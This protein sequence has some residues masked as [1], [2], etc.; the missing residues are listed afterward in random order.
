MAILPS[1]EIPCNQWLWFI[2]SRLF[3]YQTWPLTIPQWFEKAPDLP[4]RL[5]R[6]STPICAT[7]P[8]QAELADLR[9]AKE[10]TTHRQPST[11]SR[12][13]RLATA[14]QHRK[15]DASEDTPALASWSTAGHTLSPRSWTIGQAQ[16]PYSAL[17]TWFR[18]QERGRSSR[19]LVIL[20]HIHLLGDRIW[21]NLQPVTSFQHLWVE[22][23]LPHQFKASNLAGTCSWSLL[24]P[25][26]VLSAVLP[27]TE[28]SRI[29]RT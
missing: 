13:L 29:Y 28:K 23:V 7:M 3:Q 10:F 14:S 8:L 9:P 16:T 24:Q 26:T 5:C 12:Q 21:S 6:Y 18:S 2:A 22:N 11:D 27:G 17:L 1:I 4:Q 15:E 19:I 25:H 20:H